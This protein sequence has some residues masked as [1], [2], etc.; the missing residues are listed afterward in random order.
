MIYGYA[1]ISTNNKKQKLDRQF[2]ELLEKV[3]GLEPENIFSDKKTGTNMSREGLQ[4]LMQ[5]LKPG[6]VVYVTELSRLSRSTMDLLEQVNEFSR[7]GVE[8]HSLKEGFDFDCTFGK[9][10][11]TV[12]AAVS[13]LERDIIVDR[14]KEG[15]EVARLKGKQLGRPPIAK[16][17]VELALKL[18][19]EGE[20]SVSKI[21]AMTGIS[22]STFYRELKRKHLESDITPAV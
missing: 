14:V 12:L 7:L 6:D 3:P 8:F 22:R 17:K 19:D 11:L 13:T 10:I 21:L 20:Y 4:A 16:E 9:L 2:H 5:S 15:V 18:H 1:R